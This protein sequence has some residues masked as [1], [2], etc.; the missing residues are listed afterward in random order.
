MKPSIINNMAKLKI[1]LSI[2]LVIFSLGVFSQSAQWMVSSDNAKK[3]NPLEINPKNMAVGKNTFS[4]SCKACHGINADGKGRIQSPSLISETFQ[5]QTDGVIFY[6]ITTGKDKMPSFKAKLK[7]EEIWSVINY[8]RVL[9][10]PSAVPPAVDV[11]LELSA[12]DGQK[13]ITAFVHSLDSTK[14]PI[15]DVDIHF[16]LK[17]DF[18]LMRIGEPANNTKAD[19]KV[20]VNFPENI[21]GDLDGKVTVIAKVENNFLYNDTESAIGRKWGTALVSGDEKFNHRAL[22]GGRDKSPLW[23]LFMANGIIFGVWAVIIYVIYNIFRI[24]KAGKIFIK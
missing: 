22:W 12:D 2:I 14:Q 23:L 4:K 11:K 21:I 7:E 18:G 19:G 24:K 3:P 16:Y 20:T 8:L 6:K 15:Q 5:K 1:S 9:V 10:N 13:S 17:R